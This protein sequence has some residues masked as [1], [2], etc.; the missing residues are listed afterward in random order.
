VLK[1]RIEQTDRQTDGQDLYS[2]LLERTMK[3]S[4]QYVFFA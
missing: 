4:S 2:G 3:T 1:A